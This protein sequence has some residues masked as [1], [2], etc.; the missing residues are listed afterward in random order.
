MERRTSNRA[1]P[2][3]ILDSLCVS[4]VL[5]IV[6]FIYSAEKEKRLNVAIL[7]EQNY[8]CEYG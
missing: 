2:S 6:L 5:C 8:L 7:T 4:I 3:F 1:I